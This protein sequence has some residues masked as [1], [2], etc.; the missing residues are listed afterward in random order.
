MT[1][2]FTQ[3]LPFTDDVY[4]R[5]TAALQDDPPKGLVVWVGERAP[6][7]IRLL[8]VWESED[9]Y[10][11]FATERLNDI[12]QDG[13]FASTG[14]QPPEQEPAREPIDVLNVWVGAHLSNPW[15]G[16]GQVTKDQVE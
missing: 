10:K 5:F 15:P 3:V 9:N 4:Q 13:F 12:A 11:R 8:Q 16:S 6:D 1:Y 2:A 7:G 14:Y